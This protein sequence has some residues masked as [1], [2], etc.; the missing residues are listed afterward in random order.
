[1][2]K[3]MIEFFSGSKVM[4]NTFK[5]AG[6]KVLTIDNNPKLNPDICI[7]ILDFDINMLPDEF[8]SPDVVW[9]SPP[10]TTFS[11][12]GIGHHWISKKMCSNGDNC[13][14]AAPRHSRTGTQSLKNNYERSIIP[15]QLCDEI[16]MVCE[17]KQS[18]K[19][20]TLK[21]L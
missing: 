21:S 5:N 12:A 7:N 1:M 13:H 18:I 6:Y 11:V 2:T 10:C 19:Q 16:V 14:E 15:Q 8:K 20:M 17:N 9:A 3:T 4:S